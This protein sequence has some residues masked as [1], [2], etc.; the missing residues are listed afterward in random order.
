MLV[1]QEVEDKIDKNFHLQ[2]EK[3]KIVREFVFY[4]ILKCIC[5]RIGLSKIV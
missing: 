5:A 4:L 2:P 1:H 3:L